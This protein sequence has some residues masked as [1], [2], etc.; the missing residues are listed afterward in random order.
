MDR[1]TTDLAV[2]LLII[3]QSDAK[4]LCQSFNEPKPS[5][6]PRVLILGARVAQTYE[7]LDAHKMIAVMMLHCSHRGTEILVN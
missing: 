1:T 6:M 2:K 3:T 4:R 7:E 5:I